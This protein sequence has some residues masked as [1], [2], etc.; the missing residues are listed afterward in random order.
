MGKTGK[1][2]S[3]LSR[4]FVIWKKKTKEIH[5]G[6][7]STLEGNLLCWREMLHSLHGIKK[8][9]GLFINILKSWLTHTIC[10]NLYGFLVCQWWYML[11][12]FYTNWQVSLF[13]LLNWPVLWCCHQFSFQVDG[14]RWAG[15][16]WWVVLFTICDRQESFDFLF[17]R[18]A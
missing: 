16:S 1:T 18:G 17:V 14:Q 4:D 6:N 2:R 5:N 11:Y 7:H 9:P 12:T 3:F 13:Q 10:M 8:F 15:R